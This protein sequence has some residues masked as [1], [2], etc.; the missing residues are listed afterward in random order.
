MGLAQTQGDNI[1]AVAKI[2]RSV[3][4]KGFL[5]LH[6]DTDFPRQF[7][8]GAKFHTKK[9]VLEIEHYDEAKGQVKFKGYNTKEDAATLTN[10]VLE[11][12]K[13]E[14]KE[15]IKLEKGQYFWFDIV[16]CKAY[17]NDLFLGTVN[18][19][20]RYNN[21]D[22]LVAIVEESLAIKNKTKRVLIPYNDH[23]VVNVDIKNK[24]IETQN[25]LEL[26][27]A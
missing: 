23:Y 12:S 7:K 8:K 25:A 5:K 13:E 21:I 17:E 14:T 11:S 15:N 24:K 2:G 9:E 16:G 20:E 3:G 6:L 1:L 4:L 10:L 26:I 18:S 19:I 22:Y 27:E